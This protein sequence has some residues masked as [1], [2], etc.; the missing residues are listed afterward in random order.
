MV[1]VRHAARVV[2][3]SCIAVLATACMR[4]NVENFTSEPLSDRS[5]S[6]PPGNLGLLGAVKSEL[7]SMGWTQRTGRGPTIT[8]NRGPSSAETF[9]THNTRYQLLVREHLYDYCLDLDRSLN[10]EI[11]IIDAKNGEEILSVS[12]RGCQSL[13]VRRFREAVEKRS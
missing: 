7:R 11:L 2:V 13:A 10:Y 6:V 4:H 8:Q 9:D 5:I 12:G 1:I 3:L